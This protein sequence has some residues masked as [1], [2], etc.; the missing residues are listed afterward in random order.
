MIQNEDGSIRVHWWTNAEN[1]GDL[2]APWLV[3]RISG[4]KV[5]YVPKG[6]PAYLVIGSIVAHASSGCGVWGAGSFGVEK[7][8]HF[9]ADAEYFS[10]RGPLTRNKLVTNKIKCP[11]VYGD[12]ALLV[13]DY[14]QPKVDKSHDIGVVLRWSEQRWNESPEIPG[15]KKIFLRSHDIEGTIDAIASCR[16]IISSSLHGLILADAYG[17]PNMWLD[18]GTPLGLE[19]KYWDYLISVDKIK[20]PVRIDIAKPGISAEW[21]AARC[22]FDGRPMRID[23][24]ALRKACPFG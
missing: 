18:S 5:A 10:V 17:I 21:L 19:F 4:K 3:E 6:E 8:E 12:P 11:R 20:Q 14:Y 7:P 16:N 22:N 23:L 13:P 1:F 24:E 15:V 9:A 2:L